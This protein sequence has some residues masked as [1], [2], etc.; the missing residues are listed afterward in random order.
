M[1]NLITISFVLLTISTYSQ[2]PP[3]KQEPQKE[4]TIQLTEQELNL[5]FRGL[6]KMQAEEVFTLLLKLQVSFNNQ[7]PSPKQ[8]S[9]PAKP[10]TKKP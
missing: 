4:Y 2:N 1:R 8:D 5:V 10:K 9:L 6:G 7:N 3:V